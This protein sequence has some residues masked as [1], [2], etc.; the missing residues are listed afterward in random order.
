MPR[1]CQGRDTEVPP[2]VCTFG[3][4]GERSRKHPHCCFCNQDVLR[5]ACNNAR[6]LAT[7]VKAYRQL[8][9]EQKDE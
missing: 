1:F 7:A 6:K 2:R 3:A 5:D 8:T 9:E 4:N